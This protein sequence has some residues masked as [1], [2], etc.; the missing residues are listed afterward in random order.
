[1]VA[2]ALRSANEPSSSVWNPQR[3]AWTQA[4]ADVD[5]GEG[6]GGRRGAVEARHSYRQAGRCAAVLCPCSRAPLQIAAIEPSL[7]AEINSVFQASWAFA[8]RCRKEEPFI[9]ILKAPVATCSFRSWR[10]RVCGTQE[11]IPASVVG[12]IPFP[13]TCLSSYVCDLQR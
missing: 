10:V 5:V 9:W 3:A 11:V 6:V 4:E 7:F 1:M 8:R 2:S 12:L 13:T